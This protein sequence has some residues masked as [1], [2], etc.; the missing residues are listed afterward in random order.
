MS[1]TK[2]FELLNFGIKFSDINFR[3]KNQNFGQISDKIIIIGG[4]GPRVSWTTKKRGKGS[5][6]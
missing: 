5:T 2:N 4:E 6:N 3:T 1:C